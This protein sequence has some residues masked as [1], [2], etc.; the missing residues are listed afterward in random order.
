MESYQR[1]QRGEAAANFQPKRRGEP[2]TFDRLA[3]DYFA[4]ADY[5]RL[6]NSTRRTYRLVIER[7]I[8]EESIGHRLVREMT[9]EHVR[10]IISR[11]SATPGMANSVLQKIK[12]LL[13]FAIENGWRP[14]R[15]TLRMK[16][17]AKG[18]F[19]TWT[20]DE[21]A[22]YERHW[23]IGT[24]ERLAFALLLYTGQRRS[25][26]VAMSWNDVEDDIIQVV[27]LKTRRSTGAKL[28]IPIHPAL[29]E[30]LAVCEGSFR[31]DPVDELREALHGQRLRQFHGGQ[32]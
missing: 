16:K 17:F 5:L 23:P 26:V 2:G 1:A 15:P 21:I 20:E 7:L 22:Q 31:V 13:C 29:A 3:Q 12:V 30:A 19:H 27:P 28:T 10:R 8:R 18:E 4:S 9:R 25:D 24:V 11:R 32:N 14:G 6:A